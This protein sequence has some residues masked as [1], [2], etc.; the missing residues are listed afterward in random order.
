[1]TDPDR[2]HAAK[3]EAFSKFAEGFPVPLTLITE[4]KVY[5]N[6][7]LGA[8]NNAVIEVFGHPLNYYD[9]KCRKRECLS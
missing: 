3:R 1:M 8:L 7:V 4:K 6:S 9:T 5:K 2:T